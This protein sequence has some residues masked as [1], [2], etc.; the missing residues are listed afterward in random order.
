MFNFMNSRHRYFCCCLFLNSLHR[1]SS[2]HKK[3]MFSSIYPLHFSKVKILVEGHTVFR[4]Q[5]S[6]TLHQPAM[7]MK[8]LS[9]KTDHDNNR[10][11]AKE[12]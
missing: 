11:T 1:F 6:G 4:L 8:L 9:P 12:K 2:V 7:Y 5:I 3:Q 10:T